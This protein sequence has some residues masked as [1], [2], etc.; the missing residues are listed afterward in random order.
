MIAEIDNT[1]QYL[2]NMPLNDAVKIIK[3]IK[4]DSGVN[5]LTLALYNV[6]ILNN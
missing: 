4:I 3:K 5:V 2:R 6:R 1:D